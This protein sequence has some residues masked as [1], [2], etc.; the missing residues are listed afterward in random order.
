MLSATYGP[1]HEQVGTAYNTWGAVEFDV[2]LRDAA[3][4][5]WARAIAIF[6]HRNL[7]S[8]RTYALALAN[9]ASS[10]SQQGDLDK[11]RPLYERSRDLFAKYHPD[12]A[13]RTIPLEG[14]A[15]LALSSRDYRGAI[16]AYEESLGVLEHVY[17]KEDTRR[18]S[19][20]YNLAIAYD[21]LPDHAKASALVDELLEL[22]QHPGRENWQL[23][24]RAYDLQAA[25]R[26]HTNK[27]WAAAIALRERG[28]VA[29]DHDNDPYV[30][31]LLE[32]ELGRVMRNANQFRQSIPHL[33]RAV[34]YFTA[35]RGNLFTTATCEFWLAKSLWETHGDRNRA[36][37]LA[38]AAAADLAAAKTGMSLE[39]YRTEVAKWLAAHP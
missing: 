24:A 9:T 3:R 30:R 19:V 34:A 8:D 31:A 28:L 22:A 27:D 36:R 39:G 35:D 33:E 18:L 15:T 38:R 17:G 29:L 16:A 5:K 6:E 13:Q 14:L 10:W 7:E 1:E 11:A 25:I 21:R 23:V 20:L 4:D 12:H 26:E 32:Y 37:A 2:Q